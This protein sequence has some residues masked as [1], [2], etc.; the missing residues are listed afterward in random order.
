MEEITRSARHIYSL[1]A[2]TVVA[3]TGAVAISVILIVGGFGPETTT[4]I[5][6]VAVVLLVIVRETPITRMPEL[7]W[8]SNGEQT[9][10]HNTGL[11]FVRELSPIRGSVQTQYAYGQFGGSAWC[12]LSPLHPILGYEQLPGCEAEIASKTTLVFRDFRPL[13]LVSLEILRSDG[14]A[15]LATVST[16]DG[17]TAEW[18]LVPPPG[19]P[20]GEYRVKAMQAD[21]VAA[22]WV[23]VNAPT[24]PRLLVLPTELRPGERFRLWFAGFPAT[25]AIPIRVYGFRT[26]DPITTFVL[27]G[28]LVET[29][30]TDARGEAVVD[31][32]TR[33][34]DL[35]GWYLIQTDPEAQGGLAYLDRT[36]RVLPFGSS[37]TTDVANAP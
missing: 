10:D 4:S 23:L 32:Q 24:S 19:A 3:V 30:M 7:L 36:V 15:I 37:S 31:I 21:L 35:P 11:S 22:G 17:G 26:N 12:E 29:A 28:E 25:T 27:I 34:G 1:F 9:V 18:E 33:P 8:R 6:A 20:V 5:A 16:D 13:E 14:E 2:T